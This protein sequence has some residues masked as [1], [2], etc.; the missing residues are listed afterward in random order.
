MQQL[1]SF[2]L[3]A[4]TYDEDIIKDIENIC[5]GVLSPVAP[6]YIN[7][8]FYSTGGADV[9]W[10]K[11]EEDM[12]KLSEKYPTVKFKLYG[13]GERQDDVWKKIFLGG[14]MKYLLAELV[15]PGEDSVEWV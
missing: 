9:K 3:A 11:H 15:W 4:D 14:K 7:N 5:D 10:N 2:V 1:I 12:K 13:E 6:S 8:I